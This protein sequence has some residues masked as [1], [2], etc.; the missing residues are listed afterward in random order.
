MSEAHFELAYDG[1]VVRSGSMDVYELA[2]ALLAVGDLVREA[3]QAPNGERATTAVKVQ[4]DFK[5]ASFDIGLILDQTVIEHVRSLALGNFIDSETL[6]RVLFGSTGITVI[7]GVI[8][9]LKALKGE[10]PTPQTI[11]NNTTNDNSTTIIQTGS[12]Q[13]LQN[14]DSTSAELY[15]LPQIREA[16]ERI[17]RPLRTKGIESLSIKRDGKVIEV[18][19]SSE[20]EGFVSSDGSDAKSVAQNPYSRPLMVK[21]ERLSFKPGTRW[22]FSDGSSSF[23]ATIADKDFL[24]RLENRQEG[25]YKGDLLRVEMHTVQ[26]TTLDGKLSATNVIEKVYEHVQPA[27]QELLLPEGDQPS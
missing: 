20:V 22:R 2:P 15:A 18:L 19:H 13:I 4:S 16:S 26:S 1:E 5:R 24:E 10:P 3:N 9:I 17:L 23:S 8:R 25:F 21:V 27:K 6:V 12:G 7:T 14:V 11:I